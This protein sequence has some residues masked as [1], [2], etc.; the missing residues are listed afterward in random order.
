MTRALRRAPW[1][2]PKPAVT[3]F[4]S[5]IDPTLRELVRARAGGECE[6]C[7]I[8]LQGRWE[9]HH[10]K[11]R[12][13][14]GQDSACNLAALCF[15]CHRRCHQH[16]AWS[17]EQGYIVSSY[18]DPATVPMALRESR[19]VLLTVDGQYAAGEAA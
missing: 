15:L 9:A 14:G 12:S 1:Q 16:V 17:E 5:T 6:L 18:A 3:K 4:G 8:R 2:R 10:R 19:W 11:L 7:G 13:R